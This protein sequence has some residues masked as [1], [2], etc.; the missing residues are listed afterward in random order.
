MPEPLT[1]ADTVL[2][3]VRIRTLD[4]GRPWASAVAVKDGVIIAVGEHADVRDWR[5][6]RTT[7]LDLGGA[8]LVP[9]LTDGHLHPVMGV[10]MASGIDLSGCRDLD[11][12]RATLAGAARSAA[13]GEWVTGWNLDHNTFGGRPITRAAIDDVLDGVPA[14]L[15]LYDGH[16]ALVSAGALAIAGVE[17]PRGFAQRAAVVCDEQGSPTGYLLEHAA[18]D[19]VA[20]FVPRPEAAERRSRLLAVLSGMAAAGLTGG[21]VMDLQGDD[22]L[23]LLAGV[24]E[25]GEL[26]LRLR[27]APWC[28]PGADEAEL[29]RLIALQGRAGRHWQVGGVKFFIDGTVEGGTAWLEHPDCHGEGADAFWPD[30]RDFSR[31]VHHLARAGVPTATHAIGDAGVRHVLDTVEALG[32][33]PPGAARP[34]HRIEH[35]ETLPAEQVARFAPLGVVASMQP[36]HTAYTRA[37]HTDEWSRRLGDERADRAWRCRDLRNSGATLVLGSDWP[38]AHFDPRA[39]MAAARL[40]RPPGEHDTPPVQPAQALTGLMAL[41][42]Y[43]SHAALAAGEEALTG[44]IAP[45]YR[46]DLT[47]LGL[48]PVAAPAD[49]AAAAPVRLT[50]VGGHVAYRG[51]DVG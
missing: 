47:A 20:A 27:L 31:A 19:L 22:A 6:S 1:T 48:D 26:P 3:G 10:E 11:A 7:V 29:D 23:E 5:G 46:A 37:D 9:G 42:G 44:R 38:I 8:A 36:T 15:R 35:I 12:L 39:I 16:S 4:P 45:G 40:R 51:P 28:M 21:H 43:T 13:R 14:F 30:P 24:E 50:M 32:P 2:T 18:V 49:E 25:E 17:G 41:E 33:Y 34:R